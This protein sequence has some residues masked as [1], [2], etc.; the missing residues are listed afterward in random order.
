MPG[1][2]AALAPG[3]PGRVVITMYWAPGVPATPFGTAVMILPGVAPVGLGEA[4][5]I[6]CLPA[7]DWATAGLA[8]A[9]VPSTPLASP[10]MMVAPPGNV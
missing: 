9:G 10:L 5:T 8:A 3:V 1:I 7:A 2:E 6:V 4:I